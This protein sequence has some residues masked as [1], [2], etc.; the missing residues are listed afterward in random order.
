MNCNLI[1]LPGVVISCYMLFAQTSSQELCALIDQC[2]QLVYAEATR[3]FFD[4]KLSEAVHNM[5]SISS[6]SATRSGRISLTPCLL[7]VIPI[8]THF[9]YYL[10]LGQVKGVGGLSHRKSRKTILFIQIVNYRNFTLGA[11]YPF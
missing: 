9:V 3:Q 4:T 11:A 7:T 1:F 2:F 6:S 8:Y 5:T 10:C